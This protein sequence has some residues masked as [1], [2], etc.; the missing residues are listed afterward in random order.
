MRFL[1]R[2]KH[3]QIFLLLIGLPLIMQIILIVTMITSE[4]PFSGFTGTIFIFP[5]M[6]II[7]TTVFFGWFYAMG[8][9]LHNK[10][11]DS[12]NMNLTRFKI[13]LFIPVVYI[14]FICIFMV[15]V[16]DYTFANEETP[17]VGL[18]GIIVPVHLFSMFCIFYCLYF[19]AKALKAVELQRRVTFSDYAGEFF[20]IW[21]YPI[22]IWFIQPRINKLFDDT[23]KLPTSQFDFEKKL[24]E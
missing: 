14:L 5:I 13:F 8:T 20:L 23:N 21:F 11:P 1:L 18:Y 10:L 15:F 17:S 6:M 2:L 16:I 22:G 9:N 7:V 4:D 24:P 3:W 12:V 19:N